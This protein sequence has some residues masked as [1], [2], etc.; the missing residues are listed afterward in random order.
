MDPQLISLGL[1]VAVFYFL[2]IRPAQVRNKKHK[3]L[4]ASLSV[5]V[6]A[7]SVGGI[8]GTVVGFGEDTVILRVAEGVEI[9]FNK[10]A[11]GAIKEP[12]LRVVEP[13]ADDASESQGDE[14]TEEAPLSDD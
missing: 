9:E 11:I 6:H 12:G 2:I 4:V 3:E 7:V 5:G 10:G 14:P 8:N 1:L 13:V